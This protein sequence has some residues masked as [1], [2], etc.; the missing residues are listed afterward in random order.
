MDR[1][2]AIRLYRSGEEPTVSKLMALDDKIKSLKEKL[3]QYKRDSST[4]S[5]PPSTDG[6]RTKLA[7][8]PKTGRKPGGQPGHPGTYRVLIPTELVDKKMDHFPER[9]DRCSRHLNPEACAEPEAPQRWQ[10]TEIPPIKAHVTEHQAHGLQC[11]CGH[12][13]FAEIPAEVHGSQFG[14]SLAALIAYLTVVMRVPR[15]GVRDFCR[16]ILQ[17]DL[18]PAS[19]QTIVEEAS[20]ALAE[21]VQ[22][23]A[24]T[25]PTEPAI[26]ADETGWRKKRWLWIFLAARYAYFTVAKSRGSDVLIEVLGSMFRG[27]LTV[28]R[29]GA[30]T[31]YH[32]GLM[33][34]CWAHLKREFFALI[35]MGLATNNEEAVL[36]GAVMED[37][38]IKLFACWYRFRDGTIDR[39]TLIQEVQP[40]IKTLLRCLEQRRAS[41]NK[42]VRKL[43]AGLWKRREHLFTF[44]KHEGVE[45]TNNHAERGLRPAVQWRKICF[46]NR[47]DA[48][49]LA[50]SRLLTATQTCR[51]QGRDPFVFLKQAIVAYRQSEI[52]P[53]L[54]TP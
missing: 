7:P 53:S 18:S 40:T 17:T 43:A 50:T 8:P 39:Q 30:Y 34:I 33:Q 16:T 27:I 32:K 29:W 54:L 35:Q 51:I 15:R 44:V 25:L 45:P 36:F 24:K 13:T 2:Q 26:H 19:V 4:S 46:G 21:P 12:V 9:C 38:R 23:L 28:D 20:A 48:G 1:R 49:A 10:V 3:A 37:L 14:P 31:T 5:K 22:E 42:H 47:S 6:P 11:T 41:P 52:I